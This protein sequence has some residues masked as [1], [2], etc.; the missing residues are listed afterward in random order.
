MYNIKLQK[1]DS[2][3]IQGEATVMKGHFDGQKD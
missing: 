1:E 3:T 2:E